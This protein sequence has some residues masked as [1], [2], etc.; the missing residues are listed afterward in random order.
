MPTRRELLGATA[1]LAA[2][3]PQRGD[4]TP[5][6]PN[7]LFVIADDQSYPHAGA[8]GDPLAKTPHFD[9]IAR[10]GALFLRAYTASP[11]CTPSR[12]AVLTGKPIWQVGEGGVLYGTLPKDL[13]V[14]PLRLRDAGYHTGWTGKS[15]GPGDWR[16]AGRTEHPCGR[17]YNERR[18]QPAPHAGLDPRDPAANFADFLRD[19]QGPQPFCF[20][21]G[22]AEPHR[23]YDQGAGARA[24]KPL[25]QVKVPAYWPD[26]GEVRSDLLDYYEEIDW[27]DQQLGRVLK[28][29][30]EQGELD[31]TLVIVT[32]DNGMPFPRSKV[33][34]YDPGVHMPL[35]MRW[36]E[37]IKA[38]TR[39]DEF[40]MHTDLNAWI[41]EA[42]GVS[43]ESELGKLI[44]TGAAIRDFAVTAL[45]RHTMCR[46]DGAT[47][48]I[49]S[50]RTRQ[51]AYLRN[52]AP[53]R[54]P[55]GGD[56]LSSNKTKHGDVDG[57]PIKDFMTAPE[58]QKKFARQY[59]LCFGRRVAE[60]L[61]DLTQDPDETNN[62]AA[63]PEYATTLAELRRKLEAYLRDT[64]DPRLRGEDPWQK[65]P[66]RQT[67]GYG[68]SFN[69]TLSKEERDRAAGRATHKPE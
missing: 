37:K 43:G 51:F 68:A 59:Q 11:S 63:K 39:V 21:F 1:L 10:E 36:P 32:S 40:V 17:E 5:R 2:C 60:E 56:F 45:E 69:S 25:A 27:F 50:I 22:S 18:F 16:A 49:R 58:N 12:S 64:G 52:Y 6:P 8:Y 38:G 41:L 33:N 67:T 4:Q 7:L 48:P 28:L 24:G 42:A 57:A 66:Y 47:Y 23:V 62:L 3:G 61:Y 9:R 31:R 55:T 65:Y 35:A 26:T 20:W 13:A 30:E 14:W 54:W 19:R 53:D 44:R 29:I 46:P 15:W 34:L